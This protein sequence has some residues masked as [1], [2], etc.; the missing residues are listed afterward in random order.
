MFKPFLGAWH[1]RRK[2]QA[3]IFT[4]V[5]VQLEGRELKGSSYLF[6]THFEL[7]GKITSSGGYYPPQTLCVGIDFLT[8]NPDLC[9]FAYGPGPVSCTLHQPNRDSLLLV[10]KFSH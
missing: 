10:L 7:L 6:S 1:I 3:P 5:H 9:N 2:T 8:L 4:D